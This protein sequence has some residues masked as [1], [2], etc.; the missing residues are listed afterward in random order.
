[1]NPYVTAGAY[2]PSDGL[3]ATA[4]TEVVQISG[5]F[6]L[7]IGV[8]LSFKITVWGEQ[9]DWETFEYL[10]KKLPMV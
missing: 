6:R 5:W 7:G 4:E 3:L 9:W 8:T 10:R 1:M 2:V